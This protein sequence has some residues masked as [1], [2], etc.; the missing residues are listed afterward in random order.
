MYWR[1]ETIVKSGDGH[2]VTIFQESCD[3]GLLRIK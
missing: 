1:P 2:L 3:L